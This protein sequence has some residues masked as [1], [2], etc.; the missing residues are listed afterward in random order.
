MD[1]KDF[2]VNGNISNED[3]AE[4]TCLYQKNKDH[5]FVSTGNGNLFVNYVKES[6]EKHCYINNDAA[7]RKKTS[8]NV[9]SITLINIYS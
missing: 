2:D 3:S 1:Y 5:Q 7:F 4:N 9:Y 6:L 8:F